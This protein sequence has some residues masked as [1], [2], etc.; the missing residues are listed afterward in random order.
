MRALLLQIGVFVLFF[1]GCSSY[2]HRWEEHASRTASTTAGNR[3]SLSGSYEGKWQS[4]R[5][6]GTDGKLWCILEEEGPDRLLAEFRATWHG[7]FSSEHKIALH[8]TGR[9]TVNGKPAVAFAGETEIKMWVGSGKYRCTGV[10]TR[11]SFTA[12]YDAAYDRGRFI[13]SRSSP[14]KNPPSS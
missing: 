11:D 13:L 12:D 5:Y 7:V 1:T 8:V 4:N 3:P 10:L 2:D 9:K 6:K 14:P